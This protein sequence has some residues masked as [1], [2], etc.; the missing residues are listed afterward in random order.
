MAL[1][2]IAGV[3]TNTTSAAYAERVP[4][5]KLDQNDFIKLLVAQLTTQDPLNPQKDTEFI[6]QMAQFS[7][8][9][10]AKS[11]QTELRTLRANQMLG[12]TVEIQHEEDPAVTG[13][14]TAINSLNG[15]P[16]IIVGEQAYSLE[17]VIRV[18]RADS[19]TQL[20]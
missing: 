19:T 7:Q 9:E 13:I 6:G 4:I 1:D 11:M 16:K 8:L 17:D 2:G 14:V 3:T 20:A 12:Q 10:N 15:D 5:Q 18:E